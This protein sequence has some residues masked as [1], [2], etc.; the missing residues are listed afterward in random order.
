VKAL[1]PNRNEAVQIGFRLASRLGQLAVYPIDDDS[2]LDLNDS[3]RAV[4]QQRP[5]FK[6]LRDSISTVLQME[7][8][9]E[10]CV[11]GK[12]DDSRAPP[13]IE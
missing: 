10:K 11:V 4:D 7:A 1:P 2:R 9:A 5:E 6:R 3:F 13:A 12:V 8:E